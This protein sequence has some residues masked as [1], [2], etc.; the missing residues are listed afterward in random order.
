LSCINFFVRP[1]FFRK[2]VFTFTY[3]KIWLIVNDRQ[4]QEVISGEVAETRH[5][6][7]I[8]TRKRKLKSAAKQILDA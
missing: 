7:N 3:I 4:K 2:K 6:R 1:Q 8:T 5:A